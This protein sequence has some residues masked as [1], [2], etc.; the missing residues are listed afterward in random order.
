MICIYEGI[1]HVEKPDFDKI[2]KSLIDSLKNQIIDK[3]KNWNIKVIL[4]RVY[5]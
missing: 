2:F 5:S 3:F 1:K 4:N